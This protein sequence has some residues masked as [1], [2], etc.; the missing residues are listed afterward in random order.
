MDGELLND[1][2]WLARC[3]ARLIELDPQLDL[4][5]ALP[6]AEDLCGRP[7]WRA[8]VPE[9]AAQIVFDGGAVKG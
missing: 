1:E 4:V 7:R 3:L 9:T 2:S 6:I 5:L 8:M